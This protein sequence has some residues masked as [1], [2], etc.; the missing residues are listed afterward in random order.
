MSWARRNPRG[1]GK[2]MHRTRIESAGRA[3]AL[4]GWWRA[5]AGRAGT[6]KMDH[7]AG[8]RTPKISKSKDSLS[9]TRSERPWLLGAKAN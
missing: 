9:E 8:R 6:T 5:W 1:K 3:G 2:E 7:G 4:V